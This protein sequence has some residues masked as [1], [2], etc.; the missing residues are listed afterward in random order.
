MV[1]EPN[2]SATARAYA[3]DVADGSYR[4]Y[5]VAAKR[6]RRAHRVSELATVVL[7]AAIPLAA[8]LVPR[9]PQIPA[10]LGSVLVVIAGF[11]AVF[12]WQ[13]NYLRFSQSREAVDEQ[14]RLYRV[15]A[16]PYDDPAQRDAELVRAVTRIEGDEMMRWAQ[17]AQERVS[18]QRSL[19]S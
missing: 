16:P 19:P 11:R 6:S 7:S 5:L 18:P 15:G 3:M 1:V 8:V 4:W 14:R 2:D 10:V 13:E 12:H 17:I 9:L